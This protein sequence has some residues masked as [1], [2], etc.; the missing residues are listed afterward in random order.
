MKVTCNL[1]SLRNLEL[2]TS[3]PVSRCQCTIETA[4]ATFYSDMLVAV[5]FFL[6]PALLQPN[7]PVEVDQ[8]VVLK[9]LRPLCDSK[10]RKQYQHDR[11]QSDI[12]FR[13]HP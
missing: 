7:L 12:W 5:S 3:R 8:K 11:C 2:R 13:N 4:Q 1:A 10:P 9:E 6:R